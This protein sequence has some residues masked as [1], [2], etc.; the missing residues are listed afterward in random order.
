MLIV[1][2]LVF[3][4]CQTPALITQLLIVLL[5][6][7]AKACPSPF[8]FYERI[9]DLLVVANSAVNFIIYCFCSSTF[10][11]IVMAV[12]CRRDGAIPP[13]FAPQR[14]S[15]CRAS[16]AGHGGGILARSRLGNSRHG[17]TASAS[18][19]TMQPVVKSSNV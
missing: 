4:V 2:V 9:S 14:A 3:V 11:Q 8:F 5:S 18:Y 15:I 12:L 19:I 7:D 6:Q 16:F 1:V 13:S 17:S 10:R